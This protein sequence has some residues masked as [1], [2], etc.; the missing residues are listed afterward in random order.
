[1][2]GRTGA[3]IG[4]SMAVGMAIFILA[5]A[6]TLLL[7]QDSTATHAGFDR[8]TAAA[9]DTAIDRF[10]DVTGWTVYERQIT[11]HAAQDLTNE[12]LELGTALPIDSDA[13]SVLVMQDETELP[14]Q[15]D[16]TLNETVVVTNISAGTTILDLVYTEDSDL[17]A[18]EYTS[19]LDQSGISTWNQDLNVTADSDGFSNITFKD[20]S[21]LDGTASL[22]VDTTPTFRSDLLRT[23]VTYPAADETE[24]RVFDRSGQIRVTQEFTG[25]QEWTF[26]L[27]G[28]FSEM[29]AAPQDETV[30]LDQTGT[31]FSGTVEFIDFYDV[32]GFGI[33]GDDLFVNVTRDTL[34]SEITVDINLSDDDGE[35]DVLLYAHDGDYTEALPVANGFLDPYNTTVG[36]G[37]PVTGISRDRAASL[38]DNEYEDVQETLGLTGSEYNLTVD[39]VF[40]HGEPVPGGTVIS[41]EFPVPIVER[42]GNA[43]ITDKRLRVW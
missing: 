38:A 31:L 8:Q 36:M 2:A 23:T 5:T 30:D 39:T 25:E 20:L 6:S 33:A 16:D 42:Y 19:D 37:A 35:K 40:Q 12:P 28:N 17:D 3:A 7:L 21:L 26:D 41:H 27:T 34:T 10:H 14:S 15:Y 43:T 13:G 4:V 18:R 29:Y 9:A 32:R 24:V 11:V 1:M 22:D